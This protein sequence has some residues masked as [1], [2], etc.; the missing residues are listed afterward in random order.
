MSRSRGLSVERMLRNLEHHRVTDTFIFPVM[1][2]D[3]LRVPELEQ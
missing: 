2:Y 3:M 1:I